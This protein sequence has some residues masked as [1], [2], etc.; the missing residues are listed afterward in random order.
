M[1]IHFYYLEHLWSLSLIGKNLIQKPLFCVGCSASVFYFSLSWAMEITCPTS[2]FLHIFSTYL[3]PVV[4]QA[5]LSRH[6]GALSE[7]QTPKGNDYSE[8]ETLSRAQ[9]T[10]FV[11]CLYFPLYKQR[12]SEPQ[13]EGR[14][15]T[16]LYLG[17]WR[18]QTHPVVTPSEAIS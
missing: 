12:H 5:H 11:L 1:C 17:E 15:C 3:L 18:T 7:W 13:H 2:P 4:S 9:T 16:P 6:S 8:T 10:L 14:L